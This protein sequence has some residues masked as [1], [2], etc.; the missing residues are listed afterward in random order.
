VKELRN[1]YQNGVDKEIRKVDSRDKVVHNE[2][3][4]QLLLARLMSVAEKE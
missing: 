4:S 2:R 3:S 1:W